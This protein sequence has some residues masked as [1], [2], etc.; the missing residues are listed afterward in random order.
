MDVLKALWAIKASL[1][2]Y[3]DW[4]SVGMALKEEGYP[5]SVWD[6]WSQND[7]RYHP[8]E[9]EKKWNSF[10]SSATPVRGGT[11]I[12]LA[13]EQGWTP[14]DDVLDYDDTI[15]DYSSPSS[16]V[17]VPRKDPG[18][19]PVQELKTY[20]NTLF[21][22][23]E[24]IG[25]VTN[26][27]YQNADGKWVPGKGVYDK[28]VREILA[29]LDKYPDD[30]GAAIGDWKPEA[31]AWIRFN[32]LDGNGIKDENITSYRYALVE[33]DTLP[34]DAQEAIYRRLKLPIAAMVASAG[35]SIHAIVR[36]DASD[37]A[38][39]DERVRLLYSYLAE[40][41]IV[42]DKQN[43]NPSRLSRMP[44]VDR[45]GKHQALLA[46]KIGCKDWK[47][48]IQHVEEEAEGFPDIIPLSELLKVHTSLSAELIA[49]ILRRGHKML[50]SGPSKAGKSFLLLQLCVC[51]AEG[52]KWLNF[53]CVQGKTLYINMELDE[54][55]VSD[56][57]RSMYQAMSIQ[58]PHEDNIYVWTLKGETKSLP[59]I[60][61]A[62]ISKTRNMKIDAVII[63]PI[64]KILGGDENNAASISA[65]CSQLDRICK[66]LDCS[67]IYC[68]HHSKGSQAGKAS[69]DRASGSGVFAR[70]VDALLDITKPK[71]TE[72]LRA[73]CPAAGATVRIMEFTLREFPE[74]DPLGL[75][76]SHPVHQVDTTGRITAASGED[77]KTARRKD[78]D[79]QL[80]SA[81]D[82]ISASGN[83]V[84]VSD[85]ADALSISQKTVREHIKALGNYTVKNGIVTKVTDPVS[86]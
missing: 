39:Y 47:A 38:E 53:D 22:P 27:A 46:T 5:L 54:A 74:K 52:I 37:K 2:D 67:V 72:A 4:I 18:N 23:D 83:P 73:A 61:S 75:W 77:K 86:I 14:E 55:S 64:Y 29:D 13:K 30:L 32:P 40:H 26:D 80:A 42:I 1:L 78:C 44:G 12:K 24:I 16:S 34:V 6:E 62:L 17:P 15:I 8:G 41:G 69:M 43:K 25:Y 48:W 57:I 45:N 33:S 11:I 65:F 63:D 66:R 50:I 19:S 31:G 71:M 84:R 21:L 20:L 49:G 79:E 68:H 36:V 35:K 10:S 59:E 7:D 56:R 58:A 82:S 70:D 60:V 85:L 28:T 76:F 3:A 81:Y 9:C 51:I